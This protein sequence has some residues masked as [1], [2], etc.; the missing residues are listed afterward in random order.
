[1]CFAGDCVLSGPVPERTGKN[2]I[3]LWINQILW[4][5]HGFPLSFAGIVY[6][7]PHVFFPAL[8]KFD[9]FCSQPFQ[10]ALFLFLASHSQ[11]QPPT[12]SHPAQIS[13]H[14]PILLLLSPCPKLLTHVQTLALIFKPNLPLFTTTCQKKRDIKRPGKTEPKA[15]TA[16]SCNYTVQK[17]WCPAQADF[18]RYLTHS[19]SRDLQNVLA[20]FFSPKRSTTWPYLGSFFW[21]YK[22]YKIHLQLVSCPSYKHRD[23][24]EFPNERQKLAS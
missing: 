20:A 10:T 18:S 2:Q 6:K 11:S 5:P 7:Q 4:S 14:Y 22:V 13:T 12:F 17:E 24:L 3:Y 21:R 16:Q 9:L 23:Q 19:C 15:M 1:M 8:L